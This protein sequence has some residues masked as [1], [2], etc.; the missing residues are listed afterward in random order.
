MR[1]KTRAIQ[2]R[3][4]CF[5]ELATKKVFKKEQSK[6]VECKTFNKLINVVVTKQAEI[7]VI[8]I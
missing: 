2:G 8:A 6:L 5:N 3:K 7:G 4:G 1:I